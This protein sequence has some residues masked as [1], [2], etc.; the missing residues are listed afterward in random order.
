[1]HTCRGGNEQSWGRLPPINLMMQHR[2]GSRLPASVCVFVCRGEKN[3]KTTCLRLFRHKHAERSPININ[4]GSQTTTRFASDYSAVTSGTLEG[5]I[6]L[7]C[8]PFTMSVFVF[9]SQLILAWV[10]HVQSRDR[11]RVRREGARWH[12]FAAGLSG[13]TFRIRYLFILVQTRNGWT[14]VDRRRRRCS[15]SSEA[16]ASCN[17][18]DRVSLEREKELITGTGW[19]ICSRSCTDRLATL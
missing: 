6:I 11:R 13:Y 18:K 15:V 10:S 19:V 8:L 9:V 16:S 17:A 1:M 7:R 2:S 5:G 14:D 3:Q 12:S 4:L